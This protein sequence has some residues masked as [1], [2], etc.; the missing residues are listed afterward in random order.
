MYRIIQLRPDLFP[1]PSSGQ[2][3][4]T[5]ALGITGENW[6]RA[7]AILLCF[8]KAHRTHRLNT[9]RPQTKP[10]RA[11]IYLTDQDIAS[12]SGARFGPDP[13][14]EDI[15]VDPFLALDQEDLELSEE[16][17]RVDNDEERDQTLEAIEKTVSELPSLRGSSSLSDRDSRPPVSRTEIQQLVD[18]M[19]EPVRF[20]YA[21]QTFESIL[22]SVIGEDDSRDKDFEQGVDL[23]VAE[24]S[25][26]AV[27]RAETENAI[28]REENNTPE[29][30][31]AQFWQLQK[32][33][34]HVRASLPTYETALQEL[35]LDADNSRVE[36]VTLFPWQVVGAAW[37]RRMLR[38]SLGACLVADDMGLGKTNTVLASLWLATIFE[39]PTSARFDSDSPGLG[40]DQPAGIG[41][42]YKPTLIVFPTAA[43]P[44][45]LGELTERFP[46]FTFRLFGTASKTKTDL[47]AQIIESTQ[48]LISFCTQ[49]KRKSNDIQ[50]ARTIV[51]TTYGTWIKR[52]LHDRE[53]DSFPLPPETRKR[54]N[55][56]KE[57]ENSGHVQQD[58]GEDNDGASSDSESELSS[59]SYQEGVERELASWAAGYFGTI[60]CDEAHYLKNRYTHVWSSIALVGAE[61]L[62]LITATPMINRPADLTGLLSLI[63]KDEWALPAAGDDAQPQRLAL[64][65]YKA[66]EE[67]MR[68]LGTRLSSNA[69]DGFTP[70]DR[71]RHVLHPASFRYWA[72][73]EQGNMLPENAAQILPAVLMLIQMRRFMSDTIQ[74]RGETRKIGSE[75]KPYRITTVDLLPCALQSKI[76]PRIHGEIAATINRS[77]LDQRR[78]DTNTAV[79]FRYRRRLILAAH[80]TDLDRINQRRGLALRR[81]NKLFNRVPDYGATYFFKQTTPNSQYMPT[82]RDR[83][84]M[85]LYM[86]RATVKHRVLA[87]LCTRICLENEEKMIIFAEGPTSVW[88]TAATLINLGFDVLT[89]RSK[90]SSVVRAATVATFNDA[91]HKGQ[92][93]VASTKIMATSYNLQ[94]ACR[95]VVFVDIPTN[96]SVL[97]QAIGRVFRI[98]QQYH[99][100]VWILALDGSYDQR[101]QHLGAKKMVPQIAGQ[102]RLP[103]LEDEIQAVMTTR[104]D[105]LQVELDE[106]QHGMAAATDDEWE[107]LNSRARAIQGEMDDGAVRTHAREVL[108]TRKAQALYRMM[109]GQVTSRSPEEWGDL[110]HPEAKDALPA[111]QSAQNPRPTRYRILAGKL[112][113]PLRDNRQREIIY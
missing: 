88:F 11:P 113:W 12:A 10:A 17:D 111:E 69:T 78:V 62:I 75:I 4:G 87:K 35:G 72:T 45:W 6:H 80:N 58:N 70:L 38:S 18:K 92:I 22:P 95:S 31:T 19:C 20:V 63:W 48:D 74:V 82:Y 109:L 97:K 65:A 5:L 39:P 1:P 110:H 77:D 96:A 94:K 61:K 93:L 8:A 16:E 49:L 30:E 98:G 44:A 90:D 79:V 50:T 100:Q 83:P 67:A 107:N 34:N 108:R 13:P 86:A 42:P 102:G 2:S 47:K 103:Y 9:E 7:F 54:G 56:Q 91:T 24:Y 73:T 29:E 89:M 66:A 15:P 71:Y 37:I 14:P 27:T 3:T 40:S 33:L 104:R 46:N 32:Q 52:T 41:P 112:P 101:L 85:A 60:V 25:A 28:E 23:E 53:R 43:L 81:L 51:L 59:L 106:V 105:S 99:Q 68:G 64:E 21:S 26:E 36:N 57:A 76:Y 84:S 55:L